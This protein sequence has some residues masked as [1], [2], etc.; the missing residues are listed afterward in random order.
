MSAYR[1]M[2]TIPIEPEHVKELCEDRCRSCGHMC[3][4]HGQFNSERWCDG[5]IQGPSTYCDCHGF[6]PLVPDSY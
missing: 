4:E 6:L 1:E 2:A 5:K 3:K